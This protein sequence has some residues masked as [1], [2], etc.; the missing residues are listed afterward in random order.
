MLSSFLFKYF[1]AVAQLLFLKKKYV[2]LIIANICIFYL[3]NSGID[4]LFC[5]ELSMIVNIFAIKTNN[6]HL[7]MQTTLYISIISVGLFMFSIRED[8]IKQII[9]LFDLM[10]YSL[11][12]HQVV[13][14]EEYFSILS[15]IVLVGFIPFSELTMH[16]FLISSP[17]LKL[18]SFV[19]PMYISLFVMQDFVTTFSTT[20]SLNFFGKLICAFCCL[21]ILFCKQ[22]KA[23]LLNVITYLYGIQ[24]LLL[25]QLKTLNFTIEWLITAMLVIILIRTYTANRAKNCYFQNLFQ[26]FTNIQNLI[27]FAL[28]SAVFM[29]NFLVIF[30]LKLDTFYVFFIAVPIYFLIKALMVYVKNIKINNTRNQCANIK[31]FIYVLSL[32]FFLSAISIIKFTETYVYLKMPSKF[33]IIYFA[34]SVAGMW[35]IMSFFSRLHVYDVNKHTKIVSIFFLCISKVAKITISIAISTGKDFL[36]TGYKK[37]VNFSPTIFME[38]ISNIL[39]GNHVYFYIFFLLQLIIVLTIECV[40]LQ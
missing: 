36:E 38:K 34:I 27:I 28:S 37:I 14:A 3:L 32:L 22:I 20:A 33:F 24:I 29:V 17:F 5:L 10:H 18:T 30:S 23:V 13:L 16:L 21:H 8:A 6:R 25:A 7:K 39:Y 2:P 26:D 19:M 12:S 11:T 4:R 9:G 35:L 40:I 15:T 31:K 1:V